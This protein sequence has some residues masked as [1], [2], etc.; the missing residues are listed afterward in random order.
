M[1]HRKSSSQSSLARLQYLGSILV[2]ICIKNHLK[3]TFNW[4][5]SIYIRGNYIANAS[6]ILHSPSSAVISECKFTSSNHIIS[7][8]SFA[9]VLVRRSFLPIRVSFITQIVMSK[10]FATVR[11]VIETICQFV[12]I[13]MECNGIYDRELI[14]F[15]ISLEMMNELFGISVYFNR[16]LNP[17]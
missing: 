8:F 2:T 15:I 6:D 5:F 17:N 7:S 12:S 16:Y 14:T 10:V 13:D 3:P 1:I 4:R 11:E 9:S